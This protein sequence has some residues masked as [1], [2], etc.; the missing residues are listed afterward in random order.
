LIREQEIA[1]DKKRAEEEELA[2]KRAH[3][4][5]CAEAE[6]AG[7]PIPPTPQTA[8]RAPTRSVVASK[9]SMRD[10]SQFTTSDF[11]HE[12]D[13][14]DADF[15]GTLMALWKKTSSEYRS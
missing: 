3:E 12:R 14:I 13:N 9:S 11:V 2:A 15:K 4:Q 8:G 10:G 6:A 1:E 7:E 5:A